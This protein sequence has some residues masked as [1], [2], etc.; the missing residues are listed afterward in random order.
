[1]FPLPQSLQL[2]TPS[3]PNQLD[4]LS[5]SPPPQTHNMKIKTNKK[6]VREKNCQMKQ[7]VH[8]Q[9][10]EKHGVWFVLTSYSRTRGTKF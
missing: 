9:A 1:M 3:L 10:K 5:L 6:L 8:H 7:K 2:P 4:V